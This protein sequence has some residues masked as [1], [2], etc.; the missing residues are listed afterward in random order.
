MSLPFTPKEF[1]EIFARYNECVWPMQYVL[2]LLALVCVAMIFRATKSAGRAISV[3][4]AFFQVW[5]AAVYHFGFFSK[6]NPAAWFFGG[7]FIT[8][9]IVVTWYGVVRGRLNFQP[10]PG[11][12][13][14]MGT[15]MIVYALVIYPMIGYLTG[16][17]YPAVPSFGLPCP[18]TIFTLG[19]LS[20]AETPIPRVVFIIPLVW[21]AIGSL[22]AFQLGV[23]QDLGLLFAGLAAL[24]MLIRSGGGRFR[25]NA[26]SGKE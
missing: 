6:I 17:R 21:A 15:G 10:A 5:I 2:L 25:P 23:F 26:F 3:I 24:M 12:A 11:W 1:F 13:G 9:A 18:T 19:V 16:H 4:L 7:L 22:A 14:V 20:F 8:G